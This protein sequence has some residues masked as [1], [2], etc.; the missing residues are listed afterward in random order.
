MGPEKLVRRTYVLSGKRWV[1]L[2]GLFE[3][4]HW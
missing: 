1:P 3:A 4:D 2:D